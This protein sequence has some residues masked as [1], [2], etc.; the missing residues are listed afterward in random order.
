MAVT[1][2]VEKR[3]CE[4]IG[5]TCLVRGF[6]VS[7]SLPPQPLLDPQL[8]TDKQWATFLGN[9]SQFGAGERSDSSSS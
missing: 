5:N 4:E 8:T 9:C 6:R 1:G 7:L 3:H 2:W